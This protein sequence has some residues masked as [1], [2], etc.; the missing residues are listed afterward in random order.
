MLCVN[1]ISIF[2]KE[3]IYERYSAQFRTLSFFSV[4]V[5]YCYNLWKVFKTVPG[6]EL[7][8]NTSAPTPPPAFSSGLMRLFEWLPQLPFPTHVFLTWTIMLDLGPLGG[9]E[10][11]LVHQIKISKIPW[12]L[13]CLL[14]NK[15]LCF[16]IFTSKKKK[17]SIYS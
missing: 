2:K 4:D 5:S 13:K 15:A 14:K 1:Y 12:L 16:L 10:N 8:L 11:S 7:K 9:P 17:C 3:I 6:I